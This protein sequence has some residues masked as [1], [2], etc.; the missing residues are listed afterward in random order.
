VQ[1]P[2]EPRTLASAR[3][4][5][6]SARAEIKRLQRQIFESATVQKLTDDTPL[7]PAPGP[8]LED[9]PPTQLKVALQN[10]SN[11]QLRTLLGKECSRVRKFQNPRL[12][13]RIH[14]EIKARS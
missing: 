5:L 12:I 3:Q 10:M 13:A 9:L 2:S 7:S 6:G 4:E 11:Q 1:N 8:N 14:D